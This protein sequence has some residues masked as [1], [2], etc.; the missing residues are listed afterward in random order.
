MKILIFSV[1]ILI[2][3]MKIVDFTLKN[4]DDFLDVFLNDSYN[5]FLQSFSFYGGCRNSLAG[6]QFFNGLQK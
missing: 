5:L 1:K 4:L 6:W 2:S 3:L